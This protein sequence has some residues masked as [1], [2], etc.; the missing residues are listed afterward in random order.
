MALLQPFADEAGKCGDFAV[1][2]GLPDR[3]DLV[4]VPTFISFGALNKQTVTTFHRSTG[5][6][7]AMPVLGAWAIR[8]AADSQ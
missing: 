6:L 1:S 2:E 3:N 7:S 8:R 5:N 4:P